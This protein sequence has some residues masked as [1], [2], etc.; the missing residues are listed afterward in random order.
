M[1]DHGFCFGSGGR[2]EADLPTV[3]EAP[4]RQLHG[5]RR[6]GRQGQAQR[7]ASRFQRL[8]AHQLHLASKKL[9]R[10]LIEAL[11]AFASVGP[12]CWV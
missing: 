9:A 5:G 6:Q 3:H 12:L 11:L 1:C 8:V 4:H 10:D 7:P 2:Y